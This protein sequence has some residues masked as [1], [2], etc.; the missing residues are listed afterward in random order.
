MPVRKYYPAPACA[1]CGKQGGQA[2]RVKNTEYT[3]D[4]TIIRHR[5][6]NHCGFTWWTKQAG[7]ISID[8]TQEWV[9]I[10]NFNDIP[11]S[12]RRLLELRPVEK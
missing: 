10:P 7:E 5:A 9:H 4:G 1:K 12:T 6:C 3:V 8:P 2:S 11:R